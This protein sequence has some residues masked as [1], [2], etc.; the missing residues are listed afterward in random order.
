[1]TITSLLDLT[2]APD[3]AQDALDVLHETLQ[4][5]RAFPGCRSVE[6]LLDVDD[7]THVVV[8]ERWDSLAS[9]SAYRAWRAT[10]DGASRLMSVLAGPPGLT[11]FTT[12]AG[13]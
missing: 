6:V 8:L 2:L 5:T 4:A 12:A 7:A 13:D 10:P 9:D 3:S 1:V 11:R